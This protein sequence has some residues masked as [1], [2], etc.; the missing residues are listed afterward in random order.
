MKILPVR[1]LPALNLLF[2]KLGLHHDSL[3]KTK[4]RR[5]YIAAKGM[6]ELA[7]MNVK[8][9][10]TNL[11][12]FLNHKNDILRMEARIS[13]MKLSAEDPLSFLSII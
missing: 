3:E 6:R 12:D 11:A 7:L 8:E 2:V 1:L 9:S 4:N 13:M 5:W 10:H